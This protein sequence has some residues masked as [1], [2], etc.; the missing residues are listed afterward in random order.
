MQ[1][2]RLGQR[3]HFLS[4]HDS[5]SS[6][7]IRQALKVGRQKSFWPLE[8]GIAYPLDAIWDLSLLFL[9]LSKILR[10]CAMG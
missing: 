10:A 9:R 2:T 3:C 8:I 1:S 4:G 7:C 6:H 5:C